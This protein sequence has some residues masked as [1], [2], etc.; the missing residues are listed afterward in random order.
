M[1]DLTQAADNAATKLFQAIQASE[2]DS[3]NRYDLIRLAGDAI[4]RAYHEGIEQAAN[5]YKPLNLE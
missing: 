5:I 1:D 4:V 3:A 2:G